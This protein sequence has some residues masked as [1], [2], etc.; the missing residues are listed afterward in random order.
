MVILFFISRSIEMDATVRIH[1][2][3]RSDRTNYK[4]HSEWLKYSIF[5]TKWI[6]VRC[7]SISAIN[8]AFSLRLQSMNFYRMWLYGY[9]KLWWKHNWSANEHIQYTSHFIRC[10]LILVFPWSCWDFRFIN[11]LINLL[12]S[13]RSVAC[14]QPLIEIKQE[15]VG[16]R[17]AWTW[18]C[19]MANMPP[20]FHL[21]TINYE[22]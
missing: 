11:I 4:L 3:V 21:W 16:H 20:F 6:D 17:L 15:P 22:K 1:A 2:T 8:I 19:S 9:R 7:Y 10:V 18:F 14:W 5:E 12:S 13:L